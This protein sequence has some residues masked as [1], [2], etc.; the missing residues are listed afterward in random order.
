VNPKY[1]ME[2]AKI[3][4]LFEIVRQHEA[5]IR[6]LQMLMEFAAMIQTKLRMNPPAWSASFEEKILQQIEEAA[7]SEEDQPLSDY[8]RKAMSEIVVEFF[9]NVRSL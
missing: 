7:N 5:H 9:H 3:E 8:V 2:D 6:T 4:E 1:P